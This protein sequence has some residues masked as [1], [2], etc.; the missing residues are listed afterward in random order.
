[1]GG[2]CA[3]RKVLVDRISPRLKALLLALPF[4]LL[5]TIFVGVDIMAR[6]SHLPGV[7]ESVERDQLADMDT[8]FRMQRGL[9]RIK[10]LADEHVLETDRAV[11]A[12]LD[13]RIAEAEASFRQTAA[14]Y[15]QGGLSP[16]GRAAWQDLDAAVK[17]LEARLD[18]VLTLSRANDN[19]AAHRELTDLQ[20]AFDRASKSLE[21]L[22]ASKREAVRD[23]LASVATTQRAMAKL[24]A[25][26]LAGVALSIA[27]GLALA[28]AA[29]RR[30]AQLGRYAAKL[31]GSN[32]DLEAFAG[33]VAHDLREPL[34]TATLVTSR[35][36][37]AWHAP[38]EQKP[39]ATLNRSFTRMAAII[40][41]LL[42]ISR[43]NGENGNAVCDPAVVAQELR[44]D[45]TARGDADRVAIVLDVEPAKVRCSEGLLREVMWNLMD[46]AIKYRRS[47]V[48]PHVEVSGHA[49]EDGYD[50]S[51]QDNGVGIPPDA[52][53]KVF[54]PFY[55]ADIPSK[56]KG[57]G[58]GLSI[59]KRVVEAS[60]GNV[61]VT[62][63]PGSGSTFVARLPLV[64]C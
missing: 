44:E 38:R 39:L 8:A 20:G 55:R 50:L 26:S 3:K 1:M 5:A 2:Q 16:G 15:G 21:S 41:D 62:S 17:D 57:T 12:A 18:P 42:A 34:T 9:D 56:A 31:Q 36:A 51:V 7:A 48:E 53:A 59:V 13:M 28:R 54:E 33:R 23:T 61:S 47:D 14:Q 58:L 24:Q 30:N 37:R 27:L 19:A 32:R 6:A 52:T 60:G 49:S 11:M 43:V 64:R 4:V 46:N 10:I 40:D 25:M 22:I 29:Y 35:L 63:K 45:L